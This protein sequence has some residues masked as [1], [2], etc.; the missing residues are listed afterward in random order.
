M[1]KFHC[2][3]VHAWPSSRKGR[4]QTTVYTHPMSVSPY[5]AEPQSAN[6]FHLRGTTTVT[7]TI[8]CHAIY[9]HVHVHVHVHVD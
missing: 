2:N 9:I 3:N 7:V 1:M 6:E 4:V 8:Q 5:W